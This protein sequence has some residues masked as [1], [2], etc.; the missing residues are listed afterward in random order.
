MADTT[1]IEWCDSTFNPWIGCTKVSPACDHCYAETL[2]NR[3]GWAN[4]GN[5]PRQRTSK[6]TWGNP[7]K[8]QRQAD[9]FFAEHGR[10]RRVFCASLADV[11]DNQVPAAW[12]D[13]LWQLIRETPDLDW[14]LLTKRPQSI[15]KMK[16]LFWNE[17]RGRVWLGVTAENQIEADRRMPY[18]VKHR[19]CAILFVS[20]EPALGSV[21]YSPW[22]AQLDWIISGGESGPNA[23]PMH[24]DWAR[25]SR[26]QCVT[27]GVP[28]FFK[29]WGE[30]GLEKPR[31]GGDLGGDMRRDRVRIV[32]KNR[33][34]DGH[35]L[36]GDCFMGRTGKAKAG[37]LLDGVAHRAFPAPREV[38]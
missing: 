11:F 10:R 12:R 33:E 23:R 36:R 26:D 28:F 21:D 17:I 37:N 24:P 27:A 8:W 1:N 5:H 19:D 9:R 15:A 30:W 22:I 6:A 29:Q 14:L 25:A 31:A 13:D 18:L 38:G 35:F 20:H 2:A 4:W 7:R 3:F 32:E 16:P 34:A